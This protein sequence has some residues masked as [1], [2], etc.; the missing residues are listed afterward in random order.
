MIIVTYKQ[1]MEGINYLSGYYEEYTSIYKDKS[2]LQTDLK[3]WEGE[4][5]MIIL[6]IWEL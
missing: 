6:G 4:N 2:E 1:W 5:P 3:H